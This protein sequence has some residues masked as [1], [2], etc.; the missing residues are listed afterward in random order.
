MKWTQCQNFTR[1]E[2]HSP[3]WNQIPFIPT[4]M[5]AVRR[6]GGIAATHLQPNT[7]KR[8]VTSTTFQPFYP[9]ERPRTH[10]TRG[11]VSLGADMDGTEN[12][13]P[14]GIQSLDRRARNGYLYRLRH[15]GCLSPKSKQ[16]IFCSNTT[17]QWFVQPFRPT[18]PL[19]SIMGFVALAGFYC[20]KRISCT[21]LKQK[22]KTI[23]VWKTYTQ[24]GKL[25]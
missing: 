4:I 11:W 8:R 15:P 1:R 20:T 25:R 6:N 22:E 17:K 23:T 3:A 13:S 18:V 19:P 21:H 9:L 24:P 12:V 14:I 7:R 16:S 5:Q 10:Y 2:L